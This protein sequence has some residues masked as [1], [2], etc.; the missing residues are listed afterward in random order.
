MPGQQIAVVS[1]VSTEGIDP[2]DRVDFWEDYN[3]QALV[4]LTCS[5]YSEH[6]LLARQT[7]LR[8]GELRLADIAGNEHVI[9]R[10]PRMCRLQPKDSVFASLLVS[11]DAVFFHGQGCFTVTGGD[12]VLY[13]T[14]QSYL[15]GFSSPMRQL[16]VDIPRSV[17]TERCLPG[18]V[19]AP[20]V[21]GRES[22]AEGAI[23]STLRSTLAGFAAGA[24][25]RDE[26][27]VLD[28]V[29]SLAAPRAG[30]H[31]HGGPSRLIV[32]KDYIERNLGDPRLCAGQVAAALDVSTRQLSRIFA[33]EGVSPARY[34]LH[35]RLDRAHQELRR[36][37]DG[38]IAELALSLGFI[39]Q[40]HFTRVYRQRFGHTPGQLRS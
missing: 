7:N 13:D 5:P 38:T 33:D 9:E 22:A 20:M 12:L 30:E 10:T 14:R 34:V 29:Q 6:G 17:F 19:P 28:L 37:S 8:L 25:E 31:V 40:A 39:S 3:R 4:G 21:F 35:R 1:R 23:V 26:D 27:T 24:R 11:G 18:G 32:A 15:F 2:P 16:L 36:H